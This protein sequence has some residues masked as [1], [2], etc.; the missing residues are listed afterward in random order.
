MKD[1]ENEFAERKVEGGKLVQV[2]VKTDGDEISEVKL[3]G[4]FFIYPESERRNIE[5]ALFGLS[6]NTSVSEIVEVIE[7]NISSDTDFLGF[8]PKVV[9]ELVREAVGDE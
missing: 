9:A 7:E 8:S 6:V 3:T 5:D 1:T 2:S 4:D